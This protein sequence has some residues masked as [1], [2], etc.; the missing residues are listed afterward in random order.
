MLSLQMQEEG[1]DLCLY[2]HVEC[3]GRLVADEDFGVN[4]HRARN[5]RP[6]ALTAAHL[7]R[8][9][10]GI[11]CGQSH[12]RKEFGDAPF[13][14][15][16]IG[17]TQTAD[18][19]TDHRADGAAWVERA[20]CVLKHHLDAGVE[21]TSLFSMCVR[22]VLAVEENL[23]ARRCMQSREELCN[24]GFAAAALADDAEE[25]ALRK[26]EGDAV[27][28]LDASHRIVKV[29]GDVVKAQEILEMGAPST[30]YAVPL[31]RRDGGG[32]GSGVFLCMI[33]AVTVRMCRSGHLRHGRK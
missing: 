6:L 30:A 1:D 18:G 13:G 8:V 15:A 32:Y 17:R 31:P 28:C 11:G 16:F 33:S 9:A 27:D 25:F 20:H 5:C 14:I 24:G 2:G 3:R 7:V 22:D 12:L 10:C 4:C 26:G 19:F 29:H 23:P 21:G